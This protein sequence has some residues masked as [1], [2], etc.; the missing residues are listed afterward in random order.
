MWYKVLDTSLKEQF[1]LY[2]TF[3]LQTLMALWLQG[4]LVFIKFLLQKFVS[5]GNTVF[6]E[7]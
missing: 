3:K 5:D 1:V 7:T 6:Q 4:Y 2:T